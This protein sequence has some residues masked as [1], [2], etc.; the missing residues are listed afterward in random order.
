MVIILKQA[1]WVEVNAK[2]VDIVNLL[3][4]DLT[5][6]QIALKLEI[7]ARTME[8]KVSR[9]KE[10]TETKTLQ[11]LVSLFFRNKLIE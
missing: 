5:V 11:G 8:A 3:S 9:L 2:E 6:S 4:Q 1:E 7:N 10:K